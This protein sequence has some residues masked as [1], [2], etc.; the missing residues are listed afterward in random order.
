MTRQQARD[1]II[2]PRFDRIDS[3][4]PALESVLSAPQDSPESSTLFGDRVEREAQF[5]SAVKEIGG[6]GRNHRLRLRQVRRYVQL[7]I[8]ALQGLTLGVEINAAIRAD[9]SRRSHCVDELAGSLA[10][11]QG[12]SIQPRP[13]RPRPDGIL[14]DRYSATNDD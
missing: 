8:V 6:P 10:H 11:R 5:H 9:Q 7:R 3:P 14:T 13:H 1:E 12:A 2:E 4:V